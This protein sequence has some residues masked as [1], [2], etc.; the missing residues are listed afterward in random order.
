MISQPDR[1]RWRIVSTSIF[2]KTFSRNRDNTVTLALQQHIQG[3]FAYKTLATTIFERRAANIA[4]TVVLNTLA[5]NPSVNS[6]YYYTASTFHTNFKAIAGD[7][8]LEFF[9]INLQ[10]STPLGHSL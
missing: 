4:R 2:S 1:R 5:I 9:H 10:I 8:Q 7:A 6:A 3:Q